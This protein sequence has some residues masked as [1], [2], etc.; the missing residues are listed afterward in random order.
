MPP[1]GLARYSGDEIAFLASPR[2]SNEDNYLMAKL[3]RTVFRTSN[4]ALASD[5]GHADAADVLLEGAGMPAMLGA[6]TEIRKA[7]LILVVGADIAKLNPIVGSEI[8]MAARGGADLVTLSGRSTQI[9][10]LSG[11]HLWTKPGALRHAL[12]AAGQGPPRARRTG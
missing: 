3:A 4:I 8:H 2:A 6:L 7:G 10:K 1:T 11:T 12:A 5:Q 9:A